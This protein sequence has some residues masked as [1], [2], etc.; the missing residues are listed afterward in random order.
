MFFRLYTFKTKT[1]TI[2]QQLFDALSSIDL[3]GRDLLYGIKYPAPLPIVLYPTVL[4]IFECENALDVHP[5]T[6]DAQNEDNNA[7][8]IIK[9]HEPLYKLLHTCEA[10]CDTL[11]VRRCP[12]LPPPA[13]DACTKVNL[14]S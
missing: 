4:P 10:L 1:I 14:F 2:T 3:H 8:P 7:K 5:D 6:N 12:Y 11:P 13:H 9:A